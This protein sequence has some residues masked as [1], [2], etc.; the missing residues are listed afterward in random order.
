ML[1]SRFFVRALR[2]FGGADTGARD[3]RGPG[4]AS[5]GK[6]ASVD[7]VNKAHGGGGGGGKPSVNAG[8]CLSNGSIF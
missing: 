5:G 6:L 1:H 8:S 3:R 2:A 4:E 7:I